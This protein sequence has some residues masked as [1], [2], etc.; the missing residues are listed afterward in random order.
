[1]TTQIIKLTIAYSS[2]TIPPLGITLPLI[3]YFD[4]VLN[5]QSISNWYW[6]DPN[7]N[8]A[9]V[10]INTLYVENAGNYNSTEGYVIVEFA[11]TNDGLF[12]SIFGD[13]D[14]FTNVS[15]RFITNEKTYEY[16]INSNT[17]DFIITETFETPISMGLKYMSFTVVPFIYIDFPTTIFLAFDYSE[18]SITKWYNVGENLTTLSEISTND[19]SVAGSFNGLDYFTIL[20]VFTGGIKTYPSNNNNGI[21]TTDPYTI[22]DQ[23]YGITFD[24]TNSNSNIIINNATNEGVYTFTESLES[25][26][27][28]IV[29]NFNDPQPE[30]L[31]VP[32]VGFPNPLYLGFKYEIN[33]GAILNWYNMDN[34]NTCIDVDSKIKYYWP[35]IGTY[36]DDVTNNALSNFATLVPPITAI[37]ATYYTSIIL[38]ANTQTPVGLNTSISINTESLVI[39][40]CSVEFIGDCCFS[41]GTK[42]LSLTNFKNEIYE[43]NIEKSLEKSLTSQIKEE[44]ILVQDLKIGDL[45]KT[46]LHGYRRISRVLKGNFKNNPKEKGV[47]NCMYRML[48]TKDNGIIEDLTLTRNHG[49][50]VEKL[51]ENEEKKLDKNNLQVVD[52]L[53]S[54]ITADSDKFEKVEDTNVYNYYHFCLDGDGDNDRRFGIYANGLLV[55]T[56]SNNM[57]DNA[58]YIKPLDF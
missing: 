4:Y 47:A 57:M 3:L 53:L 33:S 25:L 39:Y 27:K 38:Y 5:Q 24:K 28:V 9:V 1:M 7:N 45:V 22:P 55:E 36:D 15:L 11:S 21:T 34:T 50:L 42:I 26:Y 54:I 44:Y 8:N 48:K 14:N 58:L 49:V 52:G 56:P 37:T 23:F 13:I 40:E 29:Y 16:I 20:P 6:L 35:L 41:E 19:I 17:S 32:P 43:E 10:N 46:Y 12:K 18:F 30:Q 51:S 2:G 31:P